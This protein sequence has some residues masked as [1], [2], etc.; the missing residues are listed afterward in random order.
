[1]GD[2]VV[3]SDEIVALKKTIQTLEEDLSFI[4]SLWVHHSMAI[5]YHMWI[6]TKN[7]KKV[8]VNMRDATHKELLELDQDDDIRQWI[9]D[10]HQKFDNKP[11]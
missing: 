2:S 5:V 6:K 8:W 9:E 7:G 4:Q 3:K 11:Y 1:M 10:C